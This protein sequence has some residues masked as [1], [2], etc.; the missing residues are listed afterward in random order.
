LKIKD[1]ESVT[2]DLL[3]NQS[4]RIIEIKFEDNKFDII[5]KK[6]WRKIYGQEL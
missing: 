4:D 1:P 2:P 5:P 6:I 3:Q